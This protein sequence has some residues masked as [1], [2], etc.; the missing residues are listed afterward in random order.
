M[1]TS[2]EKIKEVNPT[3]N[4]NHIE[5]REFEKYGK[6]LKSI[7]CD[8]FKNTMELFPIP[9]EFNQYVA[10]DSTLENAKIKKE[11]SENIYGG[12][13]IQIGYCNGKNSNLN[14]LEYHKG[15]E[16][17][18]AVTDLILI[19]G[20]IKDIKNNEFDSNKTEFFYL[21]KGSVVEIYQTTLHFS[22]C[23]VHKEGFKCIVILPKGTNE[24]LELAQKNLLEERELLFMKNKWLLAHPENKKLIS[25][26]AY[27]G[28]IGENFNIKIIKE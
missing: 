13:E 27:P 4:I 3:K 6:I 16:V 24:L 1:K 14:A 12:M 20:D 7:S 8:Y 23:R 25:K 21:P 9:K 22:P 5:S 19:L 17:N 11:I 15:S 2:F 28:I 10:S 18:I 26:G